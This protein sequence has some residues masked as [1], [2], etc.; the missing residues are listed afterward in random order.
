MQW[1]P[2][3][4]HLRRSSSSSMFPSLSFPLSRPDHPIMMGFEPLVNQR[5]LPPTFP[6][7]AKIIKREEMVNYFTKLIER[8]K[9]VCDVINTSNLHSI[10]VLKLCRNAWNSNRS[11]RSCFTNMRVGV[12]FF[13]SPPRTSSVSL[14]SS[15]LVYSPDL[16]YRY[17]VKLMQVT[18]ELDPH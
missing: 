7:Y 4:T 14:A 3:R 9:T 18:L 15:P 13:F 10:L 2:Q 8:I 11:I 12:S 16:Y 1:H 6:R 5:L 17:A